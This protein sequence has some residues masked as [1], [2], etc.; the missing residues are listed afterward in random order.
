MN[1][2]YV[3]SPWKLSKILQTF[4][5]T[6]TNKNWRERKLGTEKEYLEL[7]TVKWKNIRG[8]EPGL[9]FLGL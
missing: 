7:K 3:L 2:D 5:P 1:L 9:A 4:D 8:D 6:P